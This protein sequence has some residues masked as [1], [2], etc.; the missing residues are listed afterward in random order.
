VLSSHG[1]GTI[2]YLA[3]PLAASD[4]HLLLEPLAEKLNL[5][6]PLVGV[7]PDGNLVTGAVVRAVER[8]RDWLMFAC[9]ISGEPVEFDISGQQELGQITELRSLTKLSDRHVEL[10]PYQEIILQ[11]AKPG[12]PVGL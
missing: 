3:A 7:A 5:Q 12:A 2:Y 4:Y 10:E 9:N 8:E 11:I 6:R 1:S